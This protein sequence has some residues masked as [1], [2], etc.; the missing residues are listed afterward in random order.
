MYDENDGWFDHV[1]PPTA[2]R[3]TEGE[4]L[5]VEPLPSTAQGQA[6]PIGFGVRVPM[7]VVSPFSTGGNVC[8]DVFDHTS[9][10][11]FLE[12]VFGVSAPNI[13][14]WRRSTAGDLTSAFRPGPPVTRL[15]KLPVTSDSTTSPPVGPLSAAGGVDGECTG[16][17]VDR[18]RPGPD[19]H[20]IRHCQTS[21]DAGTGQGLAHASDRWF[22]PSHASDAQPW[23]VRDKPPSHER[24][25]SEWSTPHESGSDTV[26]PTVGGEGPQFAVT[27]DPVPF[28]R[29]S[30][31]LS[32]RPAATMTMVDPSHHHEIISIWVPS[33]VSYWA[34]PVG[35]EHKH[36]S[37]G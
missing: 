7:M 29:D 14:R 24:T 3:G 22:V 11:R 33:Q 35:G 18:A 2:R 27:L 34:A 8:S 28:C 13:S 16:P 30:S 26:L 21:K 23:P 36:I 5:T 15:P 37:P 19:R 1:P 6:G 4:Y 10:L 25:R 32:W 12:S 20:P 9:Q 17:G 31:P